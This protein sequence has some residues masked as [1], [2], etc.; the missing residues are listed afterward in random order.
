MEIRKNQNALSDDEKAEF[1]EAVLKFKKDGNNKTGRNYDTYVKWHIDKAM[2]AHSSPQ[3]LPWHRV[4]IRLLEEDLKEVSGNPD[5]TVPYWDWTVDNEIGSSLWKDD[6]LGGNGDASDDWKVKTGRFTGEAWELIHNQENGEPT[7]KKYLRRFFGEL[8]CELPSSRDVLNTLSITPYDSDPWN[9]G[10]ENKKS[11][12]NS[13]EGWAFPFRSQMHNRGHVWVGG[14]MLEMSSPNDPAF[15][16]H[17]CNVDRIWASWQK[18]H[19]SEDYLTSSSDGIREQLT[20][21]V[22]SNGDIYVV[23]D[24]LDLESTGVTYQE[25]VEPPVESLAKSI[26]S[27][28][29]FYE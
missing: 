12:R 6:F 24:V 18:L 3:F 28:K 14:A 7:E 15:F 25:F 4:F 19:P 9:G 1:V 13:L 27:T 26:R 23:E 21:F 2:P 29:G 5:I 11:F 17:H 22:K 8:T 16:L 10:S 20:P